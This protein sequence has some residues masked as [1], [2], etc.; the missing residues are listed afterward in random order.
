MIVK[1]KISKEK[2]LEILAKWIELYR[3]N[4]DNIVPFSPDFE[5]K[6][7]DMQNV[8]DTEEETEIE[9]IQK[10][11]HD[12]FEATRGFYPSDY[13]RSQYNLGFFGQEPNILEFKRIHNLIMAPVEEAF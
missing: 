12:K 6:D 13:L 5:F 2:S 3:N 7:A 8:K 4:V 1:N 9:Q 10:L 11:I